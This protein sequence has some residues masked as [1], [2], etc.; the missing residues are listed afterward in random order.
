MIYPKVVEMMLHTDFYPH[1]PSVVAMKQTHISYIFLAGD[2]VYKIKKPVNFGFLDFTSLDK[3]RHYCL[4]ELQLNRRLA[5]DIYLEVL[6][7]SLNDKGSYLLGSEENVV[8]YAVKMKKLPEEN[9]LKKLC[10][11]GKIDIS[12]MDAVARK[13]VSFHQLAATGGEID[14]IGSLETI[15]HNHEENFTQTAAYVDVTIRRNKYDFI[16]SYVYNFL[17]GN[18]DLFRKRIAEHKIRDC[19]GDLHLEHICIT[20]DDVVIFDCIEFNDRFRYEDVAAEAAFLSMDLDYNGC[21][22]FADAFVTAYIKYSGDSE[23]MNLLTFYKC[24]YAYVR[25]KV[26]SFRLNDQAISEDELLLAGENAGKYFDLAYEYACRME[27]PALII[28]AGLMGTGKSALSKVLA[29]HL[30]AEIIRSDVLRKELLHIAPT[31]RH[32]EDFG[33]GIYAED[34][35]HITYAKA[36]EMASEILKNGKAVIVDASYKK[37]KDRQDAYDMAKKLSADFY[38][39]ECVCPEEIVKARLERRKSKSAE[40]SDG[41]WE[42]YLAQKADFEQVLDI[43]PENHIVIDTSKERETYLNNVISQLKKM[44]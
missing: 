8:E 43:P 44:T 3:R 1:K 37:R 33:K 22:N 11:E 36:L 14:K 4:K 24:Y 15:I 41:R 20:D 39:L 9:I 28:T 21:S 38:L 5:P 35:S 19:H 23:V 7:I 42:I 27:K 31:S 32:Y 30:G 34:I 12:I 16:K 10:S 6:P 2:Y 17:A 40:V 13:V 26:I 25:G 18:K 29:S